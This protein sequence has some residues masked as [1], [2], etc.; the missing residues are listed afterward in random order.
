MLCPSC[1]RQLERAGPAC[2]HCGAPRPGAGEPYELLLGDGTHVPITGELTIGRARTNALWLDDPTVSRRHARIVGPVSGR[3]PSV[4]DAGSTHGTFLDGMRVTAA[5][6]LRDGAEIRLGDRRLRAQCRRPEGA[7]GRPIV[8]GRG[9]SLRLPAAGAAAA[10][11]P[12][13]P[14]AGPRPRMRSGYALKRLDASEGP[15]RWVIR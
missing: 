9:A 7:A 8:V 13:A 10:L 11:L 6:P 15:D 14:P 5:T 1:R 3:P 4:E 12:E 2:P